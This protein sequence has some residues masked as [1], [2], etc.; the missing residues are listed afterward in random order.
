[1]HDEPENIVRLCRV[2]LDV[3]TKAVR[4]IVKSTWG[5]ETVRIFSF[6][7]QATTPWTVPVEDGPHWRDVVAKVDPADLL[8]PDSG[9]EKS[10][11]VRLHGA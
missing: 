8:P 3:H 7:P 5:D 2:K 6:E 4:L 9:L 1:M 10:D 11:Q